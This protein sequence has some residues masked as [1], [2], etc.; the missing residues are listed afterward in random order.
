VDFSDVIKKRKM[1]RAYTDEP[2]A[3]EA[4]ERI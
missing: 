2:V 3:P 1:V 4:V